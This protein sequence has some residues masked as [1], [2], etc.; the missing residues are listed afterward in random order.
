MSLQRS[1]PKVRWDVANQA[2]AHLP[3][4]DPNA[5]AFDSLERAIS[6][7][8]ET[9]STVGLS[10]DAGGNLNGLAPPLGLDNLFS[11]ALKP[12]PFLRDQPHSA[13]ACRTRPFSHAGPD[14]PVPRRDEALSWC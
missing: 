4:G 14:S 3:S 8:P 13:D 12:S 11:L 6:A 7:W 2:Y 9:V 1:A 5:S 10:L